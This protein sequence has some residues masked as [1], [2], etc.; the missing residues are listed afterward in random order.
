MADSFQHVGQQRRARALYGA[1]ANLLAVEHA[2]NRH[3]FG[4]RGL[5]EAPGAAPD[6]F[7]IIQRGRGDVFPFHPPDRRLLPNVEIQVVTQNSAAGLLFQLRQQLSR[8]VLAAQKRQHIHRR[9]P[10]I[11][12]VDLPVHMDGNAGNQQQIPVDIHQTAL[13]ALLRLHRHPSGD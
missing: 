11:A 12:I 2:Q 4:G 7:Q 3:H 8:G 1:G 6:A 5:Q 10:L 9:I 13:Y